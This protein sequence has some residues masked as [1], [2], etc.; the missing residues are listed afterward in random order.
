[1]LLKA[2]VKLY[3]KRI[4]KFF[5]SKFLKKEN[6]NQLLRVLDLKNKRMKSSQKS[7]LR[8]N[9]NIITNSLRNS[10]IS[11]LRFCSDR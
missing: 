9:K 6:N 1:M 8:R 11:S 5:F 2:F 3:P 4:F 10:T 7:S